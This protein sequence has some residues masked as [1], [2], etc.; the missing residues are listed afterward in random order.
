MEAEALGKISE[1]DVLNFIWKNIICI[2]GIPRVLISDNGKQFQGK[3]IMEWC[4]ELKIQQN[5]TAVGNPRANGQTEVS[6]KILLQHL[7]TKLDGAKGS[8]VEE[9]PGVLWAYR[10]TPKTA[11]GETSFCLVYG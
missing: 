9:L 3:K 4:K 7:K 11:T 8:W 6:N 10:T 2:F 5:C 1:K